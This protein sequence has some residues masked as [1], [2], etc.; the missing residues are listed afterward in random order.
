MTEDIPVLDRLSDSAPELDELAICGLALRPMPYNR[1]IATY[2]G[3]V[4]H[5][6]LLRGVQ[7]EQ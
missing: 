1:I 7:G 6:R 5:L 3:S 4:K 2:A